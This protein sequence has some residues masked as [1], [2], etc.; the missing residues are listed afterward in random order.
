V[1]SWT[2]ELLAQ[3][4]WHWDA[5]LRPR[6]TGLTDDEYFWE[7]VDGCWS[8]RLRSEPGS[9]RPRGRG[10]FRL[11]SEFPPPDP[12]PVTTIA[13]RLAHVIVGVFGERNA[14]YFG[15]PPMT[16]GDAD[17]AGTAAQAL[18]QLDA[19]EAIWRAGVTGLTEADLETNCR[20]PGFETD[21]MAAL[22][23]HIH[24]EVLHHG[25]ELALLRDLY[26]HR[27]LR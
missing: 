11:D 20:E 9:S 21:S 1:K 23:L 14:T 7:P 2:Q 3:H 16:W 25:A 5:Q 13:W 18:E 10:E 8:V 22:I 19:G 27:P 6:L 4:V 17:Y 26:A 15:G 12:A 24:R